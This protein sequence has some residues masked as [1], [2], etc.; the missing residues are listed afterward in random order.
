MWPHAKKKWPH[1]PKLE[2]EF[3]NLSH[4]TAPAGCISTIGH[5]IFSP[6]PIIGIRI[7]KIY[8]I[9]RNLLKL[10]QGAFQLLGTKS[11][12]CAAH[13]SFQFH[14]DYNRWYWFRYLGKMLPTDDCH[15]H[16]SFPLHRRFQC[17]Q[18]GERVGA[19]GEDGNPQTQSTKSLSVKIH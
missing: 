13:K 16:L 18:L 17:D 3:T 7:Y 9:R 19:L 15:L 8:R 14:L 1:C 6:L 10:L 4:Y 5:E 2:V 11:S 12:A